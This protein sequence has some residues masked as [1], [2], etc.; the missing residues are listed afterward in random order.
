M[1]PLTQP[2]VVLKQ[3]FA[4]SSLHHFEE[5]VRSESTLVVEGLWDSPKALVIAR[6]QAA[7][8]RHVL[9]LSGGARENRLLDDLPLFSSVP[10]VEFPAWETLP[11][12]EIP[13][14]PDVVGER[15]ALLR[16][17]LQPFTPT[18]ILCPL[19]ACLQRVLAPEALRPLLQT[20]RVGDKLPFSAFIARLEAMGFERRVVAADKGEFAVRGGIIDLFP[21]DSPDP[22]RLEFWGDEIESMRRYDP[23]G[24][25]SVGPTEV[26]H[27]IPAKEAELLAGGAATA[28][29]LEYM[30]PQTL[31]FFD[32]LLA[33]EDRY[34]ALGEIPTGAARS[35][36]G[37]QSFLDEAASFQKIYSAATALEE[38]GAVKVERESGGYYSLTG[39]P[40]KVSFP[41]FERELEAVRWHHPFEALADALGDEDIRAALALTRS[42]DFEFIL[43]ADSEYEL[44]PYRELL[45][46]QRIFVQGYLSSG[47]VVRDAAVAVLPTTELTHRYRLRRRKQRSTYHTAPSEFERL[48]EGELIVH[49]EQG[50]GRY[51]GLETRPD[52]TGQEAEFLAVEYAEKGKLYV[53]LTQSHLLSRYIGSQDELPPLSKLGSGRWAR[54]RLIT[55]QAI[56]DYAGQLLRM[57]A[58]REM[59]GGVAFPRDSDEMARFEGEFPY[60]ETEDQLQAIAQVKADME[61]PRPMDRLICGD[62]GYGKTEVAMRAAF[63][64]AEA[65]KQVAVLVPTTILAMQHLETFSERMSNFPVRVALLSRLQ[66]SS[67]VRKTLVDLEA[68]KIDILIGT[69]K[70]IGAEVVFKDLGLVIIDEEQRFGVRVKEKVRAFRAGV[71]CLTLTATPIPRTLYLSLMGA[72]DLSIIQTPPQDRLPIK[73]IITPSDDERIKQA[74]LR[75]L[76]RDGQVYF[77]HNRIES[78]ERVAEKIRTLLPQA[79]LGVAHGQMTADQLEALFHAFKQGEIDILIATTII[80]NGV[81]IPNANTILVDR[82]DRYGLADLYQLRGRVGRWS[83]RAYAYFLTPPAGVLSEESQQR[84]RAL[85]QI[86]GF[87]GGMKL[88]MADLQI[89]G[90]GNILGVEQSGHVSR[91]G[92]NLYCRLLKR[93]IESLRSGSTLS[94]TPVRLEFPFNYRIPEAYLAEPELR[95]E[96]SQ[97][98][99]EAET[100]EELQTLLEEMR[101]RFGSPPEAVRWLYHLMRIRILATRLSIAALAL[102]RLTLHVEYR[103]KKRRSIPLGE[104]K[105]PDHLERRVREVLR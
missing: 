41:M 103:N 47:F 73:T 93:T 105:G 78:I 76:A 13:P 54:T 16:Q 70:M 24:Q 4:S 43:V 88:A 33:L 32:D 104:I 27:L 28:S 53:P 1:R 79:R 63:K 29:L 10:V 2:A 81:D 95:M 99:G 96:F 60:V 3:V 87:G 12:E 46:P 25:K 72:R 98:L 101:D 48:V 7:S 85:L 38:L 51:L 58:D 80:E 42:H 8:G 23:V 39:P 86:G 68:G 30:G 14:S 5:S 6:A 45:P 34:V 9:V 19:Q 22:V 62:V 97:R 21:V 49:Y 83:R 59:A 82:A 18:I 77:I 40:L 90:A 57:H 17:L 35:F 74:L 100:E 56:R 84:L 20:I 91:I 61:A 64:A 66:K 52:H 69:H 37:F 71:D 55:E 50:I 11:S 36:L 65:G 15:Y 89:R 26:L 44:E 94:L 67:Q 31:I 75:E 102:K 92:F